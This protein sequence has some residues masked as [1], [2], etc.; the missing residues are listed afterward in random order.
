MSDDTQVT[1]ET[2]D[3]QKVETTLDAITNAAK[4]FEQL[5]FQ[6]DPF[7]GFEKRPLLGA[8]VKIGVE[9]H[10]NKNLQ[11]GDQLVVLIQDADGEVLSMGDAH[12]EDVAFK[13]VKDSGDIIGQQRQHKAKLD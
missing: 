3:G 7:P 12:V 11:P 5:S 13:P 8:T 9:L 6:V 2:A 1:I 10:V 4:A